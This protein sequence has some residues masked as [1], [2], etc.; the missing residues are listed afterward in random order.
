MKNKIGFSFLIVLPLMLLLGDY[1]V[2][3]TDIDH[4]AKKNTQR[5]NEKRFVVLIYRSLGEVLSEKIVN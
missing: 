4:Q 3:P 5:L 2:A 1:D